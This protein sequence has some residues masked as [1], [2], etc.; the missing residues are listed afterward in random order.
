M[1]EGM[2]GVTGCSIKV[3]ETIR[4]WVD[5]HLPASLF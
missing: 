3:G 4:P 5:S 2:S 1:A